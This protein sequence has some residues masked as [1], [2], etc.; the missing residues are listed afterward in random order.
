[1]FGIKIDWYG[2]FIDYLKI[3]YFDDDM[4]KKERN[5]LVIKARPYTLCDGHLH[6]LRSTGVLR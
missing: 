6:K 5:Q 4:P 3:D 2:E 1:L